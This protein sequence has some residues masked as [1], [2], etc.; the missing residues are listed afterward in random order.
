MP[1]L[2]DHPFVETGTNICIEDEIV[3]N[4]QMK[5]ENEE[6]GKLQVR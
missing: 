6:L 3:K 1:Q 4:K 2:L 5:I